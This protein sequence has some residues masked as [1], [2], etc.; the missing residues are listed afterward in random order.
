MV[1]KGVVDVDDAATW[2][3]VL[4]ERVDE[5]VERKRCK[6]KRTCDLHIHEDE[7]LVGM[8]DGYLVRAFHCTR[9]L[10]HERVM[11]REQGLRALSPDLVLERIHRA[12]GVGAL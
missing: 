4:C 5:W 1:M 9:L 2:P 7:A 12:H 8:L 11:I 6:T 10:D 3:A